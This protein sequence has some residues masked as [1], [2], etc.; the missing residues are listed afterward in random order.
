MYFTKAKYYFGSRIKFCRK[1]PKR[2]KYRATLILSPHA[3]WSREQRKKK[4]L[5]RLRQHSPLEPDPLLVIILLAPLCHF[6]LVPL[7]S[8]SLKAHAQDD[9]YQNGDQDSNLQHY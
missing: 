9:F 4:G 5:C 7:P 1:S 6:F 8:L 3:S 2:K